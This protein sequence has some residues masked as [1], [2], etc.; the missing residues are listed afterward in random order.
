MRLPAVGTISAWTHADMVGRIQLD[1]GTELRVGATALRS[2]VPA[3]GTR[4]RVTQVE[5]HRLGGLRAAEVHPADS[6]SSP[7]RQ[8]QAIYEVVVAR[9]LG[10]TSSLARMDWV[11]PEP[12]TDAQRA[13][14][15]AH[16]AHREQAEHQ[17][18][19]RA[20]AAQEALLA[21]RRARA[22]R[23]LVTAWGPL[24][25]EAGLTQRA[26]AEALRTARPAAGF[27]ATLDVSSSTEIRSRIGGLPDV[28]PGVGWPS[29]DGTRLTFL[30]QLRLAEVPASVR[31]DLS[32]PEDGLLSFFYEAIDQPVGDEPSDRGAARVF[33]FD[34]VDV[35]GRAKR[36]RDLDDDP[37]PEGRL[38]LVE[39]LS[40]S[41]PYA[42]ESEQAARGAVLH[43]VGGHPDVIHD[44]APELAGGPWRLL[45]QLD[46][47]LL[48]DM[49]WGDAGRLHFWIREDRLRARAFDDVRCI[50]HAQ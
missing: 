43:K 32:L 29:F 26:V 18:R 5:P 30:A 15:D 1:D 20:L 40:L 47:D 8:A 38:H 50:L 17:E 11:T 24:L 34:D 44:D 46:S 6:I 42:S 25:R 33:W 14:L 4:V 31:T 3:V 28:A 9:G 22:E 7:E 12:L 27:L 49:E 35:L 2:V 48:H 37:L 21:V 23:G 45:L 41:P 16:E 10:P 13:D 19:A 39:E 36:P